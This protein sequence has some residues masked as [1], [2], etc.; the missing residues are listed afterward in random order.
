MSAGT[1]VKKLHSSDPEKHYQMDT[2]HWNDVT[3]PEAAVRRSRRLT[4]LAFHTLY[5]QRKWGHLKFEELDFDFEKPLVPN[6]EALL[7]RQSSLNSIQSSHSGKRSINFG[8]WWTTAI[9]GLPILAFTTALLA[10]VFIYKVSN[11]TTHPFGAPA[12]AAPDRQSILVNFSATRLTFVASWSSTLAPMLLGSLMMLWHI[13]TACKLAS[14]STQDNVENLPT[15]HQFSM[16]IGLASGSLDNLRKYFVYQLTKVRA[17]QP[18]ILTRSVIVLLISSLL[19]LLVFCADT[20]VHAFTSTVSFSRVERQAQSSKS[21]GRGLLSECINF[22]RETHQGLPCT[23]IADSSV[24][25]NVIARNAGEVISLQRNVS[26]QNSI[27]T[28]QDEKLKDGDLL[29]LMP[30]ITNIPPNIDYHTTTVGVSTQC[31]PSSRRCD[32]RMSGGTS[33]ATSYIMFNCTDNFRGVLGADPGISNDTLIWTHTDS[34]TPDFNFKYDRNFQYA[35]FSDPG[36]NAIYNSIGGNTT[37]GGASGELAL[38]DNELINPVFL[39]TAGLIPL[40][41]GPAGQSLSKDSEIFSVGGALAAYTLSC[42]VTSYDVSYDWI[43]GTIDSFKYIATE[44][45]S[46]VELAH[47]MQATGMPALSQAQSLASLSD[48]AAALAR[49]FAN[50]HSENSLTLIASVMS[51]RTNIAEAVRENLLVAKMNS[52]AFGFLIG[53]NLLYVIFGLVLAI[54]AW[55]LD[56][57]EARDMVAR[58]SVEGLAAMAFEDTVEKRVRRVDDTKDMFEE[59]RIGDSSRRVGIK[60]YHGGGH[61]MFVEQPRL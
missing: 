18:R 56:S 52:G 36:L 21:F 25:A 3:P 13:P 17:N 55:R 49:S 35:Y 59:S 53:S 60:A 22:D 28:V 32:V 33:P 34:T 2:P 24:G 45:G 8:L 46:I 31:V 41:N 38:P 15:P 47:A 23:V 50:Q 37:N 39:A 16:L 19:A 48:S 7:P 51:P 57:P 12:K 61:V 11:D 20:A 40:Q 6:K 10:L 26:T 42:S 27:W 43:N 30:Q 4:P 54:R 14:A 5:R 58:M 29:I 1:S 44:N 9:I